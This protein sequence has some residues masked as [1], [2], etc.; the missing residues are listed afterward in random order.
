MQVNIKTIPMKQIPE[1]M[2]QIRRKI[3]TCEMELAQIRKELA[4]LE[5]SSLEEQLGRILQCEKKL[6]HF[7]RYCTL[8]GTA[9]TQICRQYENTEARIIDYNENVKKKALRESVS[10]RN[11]SD[12]RGLLEKMMW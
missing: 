11:L 9:V 5:L 7:A 10:R 1:D 4:E 12:L 3:N 6:A 8:F 2:A